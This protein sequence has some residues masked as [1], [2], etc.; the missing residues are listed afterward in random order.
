LPRWIDSPQQF[1]T[2]KDAANFVGCSVDTIYRII[3]R[4]ELGPKGATKKLVE[5]RYRPSYRIKKTAFLKWA[6]FSEDN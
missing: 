6:N 4:G 2:A 5:N 3:Q 1:I